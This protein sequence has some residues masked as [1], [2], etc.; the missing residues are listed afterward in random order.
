MSTGFMRVEAVCSS[1]PPSDCCTDVAQGRD[2]HVPMALTQLPLNGPNRDMDVHMDVHVNVQLLLLPQ[3][4][5]HN[6]NPGESGSGG[7]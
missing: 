4:L 1:P 6:W 5:S 2:S 3:H 7:T